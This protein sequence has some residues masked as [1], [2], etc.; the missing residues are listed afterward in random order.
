MY[1]NLF[2][3]LALSLGLISCSK[4]DRFRQKLNGVYE[5]QEYKQ[6]YFL[7]GELNDTKVIAD[8]G[9]IGLYD[10]GI[11]P[12][13]SISDNLDTLPESW[14]NNGVGVQG[15]SVGWYSDEVNGETLN[16]FSE[17]DNGETFFMTFT[18]DEGSGKKAEWIYVEIYPSGKLKYRETWKVKKL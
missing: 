7:E 10:N 13:N 9:S 2:I 1:R 5:V 11:T 14:A 12:Y 3:L 18:I 6:E 17:K 16:F 4:D 8:F 15:L